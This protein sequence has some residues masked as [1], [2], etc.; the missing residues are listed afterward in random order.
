MSQIGYNTQILVDDGASNAYVAFPDAFAYSHPAPEW[1]T[2]EATNLDASNRYRQYLATMKEP[3]EASFK[4]RYTEDYLDR[5][6]DLWD[7]ANHNWKA[8]FP[9]GTYGIYPGILTKIELG[10]ITP[11]AVME[12][13]VSIKVT[14]P[15]VYTTA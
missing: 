8:I 14:G 1:G 12:M 5:L 10:E 4:Q 2:V 13:T 7:G 6:V 11:D 15:V 3:G 9:D